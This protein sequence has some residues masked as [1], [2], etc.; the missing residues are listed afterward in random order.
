MTDICREDIEK[1]ASSI[2]EAV[3]VLFKR[4]RQINDEQK[5]QIDLEIGPNQII[6]NREN[7]DYDDVE[8][9]K[10]ALRREYKKFPK[11]TRA[12][13][14]E[15]VQNKIHFEYIIKEKEGENNKTVS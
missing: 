13:L 2:Y 7:E 14:N 6:D 10:E 12:A 8:I 4:A 5:Q 3:V 9:D 11:P 1:K 15:M